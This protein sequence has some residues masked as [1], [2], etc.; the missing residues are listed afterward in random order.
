MSNWWLMCCS[1][2]VHASSKSL[3][4]SR[5]TLFWVPWKGAVSFIS[6]MWPHPGLLRTPVVAVVQIFPYAKQ[7]VLGHGFVPWEFSPCH[8]TLTSSLFDQ[9]LG[10][11]QRHLSAS[12]CFFHEEPF[13]SIES[14][15]QSS[16]CCS[17]R[18]TLCWVLI[19]MKMM[20]EIAHGAMVVDSHTKE[21]GVF[22]FGRN[23]SKSMHSTAPEW[24][25]AAEPAYM[26]TTSNHFLIFWQCQTD[27]W[28][29]ALRW[30]MR[31]PKACSGVETHYFGSHERAPLVL[32]LEC[33]HTLASC[34]PSWWPWCRF[35][36]M[37]SN[38][39]WDMASY[40]EN[41]HHAMKPWHPL[42]L[43]KDLAATKDTSP[44]QDASSMKSPSVQ[45]NPYLSLPGVV[46]DGTRHERAA[47]TPQ[48]LAAT[49]H[50][51]QVAGT[52]FCGQELWIFA[53]YASSEASRSHA[54]GVH[55]GLSTSLPGTAP[56]GLVSQCFL[57]QFNSQ[58]IRQNGTISH[59]RIRSGIHFRR[60][61]LLPTL[62]WSRWDTAS[63][64]TKLLGQIVK[65]SWFDF[66]LV[67]FWMFG[68]H[69][70]LGRAWAARLKHLPQWRTLCT[71]LFVRWAWWTVRNLVQPKSWF[72]GSKALL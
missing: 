48:P 39:F 12:G 18:D 68:R 59:W 50:D 53:S 20:L 56:A 65:V 71:N 28:C 9:R 31:H 67:R 55:E 6:G 3:F 61:P 26:R 41:S 29:V 22:P 23:I 17:G 1:A 5:D 51:Q 49:H 32:S 72:E 7:Q 44:L 24:S 4:W 36:H 37:Q 63:L 46:Q 8:E 43:I 60:R 69:G 11:D 52:S 54:P 16:R 2:L 34:G 10:C 58:L 13:S 57:C 40:L 64:W 33:D 35:F 47:L 70:I 62:L 27:D 66:F 45:S 38:K 21:K 42:C 30:F 15:S 14:I 19:G 25:I